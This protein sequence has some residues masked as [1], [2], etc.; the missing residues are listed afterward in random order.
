MGE[1]RAIV[2]E[3][4]KKKERVSPSVGGDLESK[5]HL[6]PG[7]TFVLPNYATVVFS[8]AVKYYSNNFNVFICDE[9]L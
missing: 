6:L 4:K 9:G 7:A 1:P 8:L 5:G 2:Q 3:Q